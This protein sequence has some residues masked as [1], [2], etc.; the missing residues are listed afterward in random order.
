MI[1][2][3]CK[4]NIDYDPVKFVCACA[5]AWLPVDGKMVQQPQK[6]GGPAVEFRI[7]RD[8]KRKRVIQK[9]KRQLAKG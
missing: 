9:G 8:G 6:S 5:T 4:F 7:G 1:C 3:V 2:P